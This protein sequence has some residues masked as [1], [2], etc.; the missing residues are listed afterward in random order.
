VIMVMNIHIQRNAENFDQINNQELLK[1]SA[2]WCY[3][4]VGCLVGCWVG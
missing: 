1:D 2:S 4:S 3:L